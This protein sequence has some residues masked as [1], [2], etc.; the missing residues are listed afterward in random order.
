MSLKIEEKTK[1]ESISDYGLSLRRLAAQAYP[2]LN[3]KSIESIVIDQFVEGMGNHDL[4]RYVQLMNKPRTLDEAISFAI[5]FEAFEGPVEQ[6]NKPHFSEE[7]TLHT[8]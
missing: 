2:H 3:F 6:L 5:E 7:V 1:D 4:K 8:Y